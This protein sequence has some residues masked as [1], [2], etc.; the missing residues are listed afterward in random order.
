MTIRAELP[1]RLASEAEPG[2]P[3]IGWLDRR[4][5]GSRVRRQRLEAF[6][7]E[8]D[9]L[10]DEMHD[11]EL[12]EPTVEDYAERWGVA[13]SSAYRLLDEFRQAT[14][15]DNPGA[16]CELLWSGMPSFS[17]RD[18]APRPKWLLAVEVV[19]TAEHGK[20]PDAMA[21]A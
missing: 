1:L 12:R 21:M 19:E 20:Q 15:I 11:Q 7:Q 18:R 4:L 14:M 8:W 9:H 17:G 6:I 13:I 16:L 2:A 3:F 10:R 5:K